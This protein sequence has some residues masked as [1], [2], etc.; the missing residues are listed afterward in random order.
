MIRL[1][2]EHGDS[3]PQQRK[4]LDDTQRRL[5]VLFDGL[6]CETIPAGSVAQLGEMVKGKFVRV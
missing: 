3:Q 6:N 1:L 5:N 2:T 4:F